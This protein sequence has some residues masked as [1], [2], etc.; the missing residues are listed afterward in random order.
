MRYKI[1]KYLE[2]Y[3]AEYDPGIKRLTLNRK[4]N[5][6]DFV[7]LKRVLQYLD[8]DLDDIVVRS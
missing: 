6:G 2:Q 4:I 5:V 3:D 7:E 1:I 8:V